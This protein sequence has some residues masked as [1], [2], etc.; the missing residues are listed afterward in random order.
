[1]GIAEGERGIA[2]LPVIH[3]VETRFNILFTHV[4]QHTDNHAH[5]I[6]NKEEVGDDPL[7]RILEV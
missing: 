5:H 2:A 4:L 7:A 3:E 1:M 6:V